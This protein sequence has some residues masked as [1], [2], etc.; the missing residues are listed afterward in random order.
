[1][2]YQVIYKG[3]DLGAVFASAQGQVDNACRRIVRQGQDTLHAVCVASTPERYGTL[4]DSWIAEPIEH[5]GNRYVGKVTNST[6]YGA[7]VETGSQ[8]HEIDPKK[9]RSITTPEGERASAHHPGFHGYHM[10]Q[11]AAATLHATIDL[12]AEAALEY[13]KRQVE[14]EMQ[15]KAGVIH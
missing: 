10:S 9:K 5:V 13:W 11:K 7:I 4:R 15:I 12:L 8:P 1:M 3:P 14:I 2:A 6:W